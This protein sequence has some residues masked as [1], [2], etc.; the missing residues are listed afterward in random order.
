MQEPANPARPASD[1][2]SPPAPPVHPRVHVVGTQDEVYPEPFLTLEQRF[3]PS[4]GALVTFPSPGPLVVVPPPPPAVAPGPQ[5][6]LP[7]G[8]VVPL[9]SLDYAAAIGQ[10]LP[11]PARQPGTR[12]Y[13]PNAD[14]PGR[15]RDFV[16]KFG[17]PDDFR[18]FYFRRCGAIL[19]ELRPGANCVIKSGDLVYARDGLASGGRNQH[20]AYLP[21]QIEALVVAGA[22]GTVTHNLGN[23]VRLSDGEITYQVAEVLPSIRPVVGPRNV[24]LVFGRRLV[25]VR[26]KTVTEPDAALRR[27]IGPTDS[28]TNNLRYGLVAESVKPKEALLVGHLNLARNANQRVLD[29]APG[30]IVDPLD[31]LASLREARTALGVRDALFGN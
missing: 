20:G 26:L 22:F 25:S 15:A 16:I 9:E 13:V 1:P 12:W 5:P 10:D 27:V 19:W 7:S 23:T 2:P 24:P 6:P 4:L 17:V 8:P 28:A 29:G 21:N 3:G 30:Q 31:L 18:L 11:P 14:L